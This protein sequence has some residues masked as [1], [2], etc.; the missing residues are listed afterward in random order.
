MPAIAIAGP[1]FVNNTS[2]GVLAVPWEVTGNAIETGVSVVG[3]TPVPLSAMLCGLSGAL[4]VIVIVPVRAP[5]AEGM[6][7][8]EIVHDAPPASAAPQLLVWVKSLDDTIP[9]IEMAVDPLFLSVT[10]I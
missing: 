1:L 2:T 3:I 10:G 5:V 8:T 6:N 7:V 9:P 4:S